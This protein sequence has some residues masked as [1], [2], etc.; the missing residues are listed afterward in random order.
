[1]RSHK[2]KLYYHY[3]VDR[4][5]KINVLNKKKDTRIIC[6]DNTRPYFYIVVMKHCEIIY[7]TCKKKKKDNFQNITNSQEFRVSIIMDFFLT[8]LIYEFAYIIF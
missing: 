3:Y 1:M 6:R 5:Y 4:I 7:Y 8:H 2:I